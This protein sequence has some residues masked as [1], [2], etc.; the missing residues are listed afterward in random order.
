MRLKSLLAGGAAIA[1]LAATPSNA[2]VI[3]LIDQGFAGT[4][5]QQAQFRQGFQIAANYWGSILTNN[6]TI[7]LGVGTSALGTGI[8]GS[9]GS[10]RNDVTTA[11]WLAGINATKSSGALDTALVLPTL[12]AGGASF[13]TN[14]VNAAS[15][16]DD[17]TTLRYVNGNTTSAD[18]LYM[19]TSVVKA[20]GRT[21]SYN[22]NP[23]STGYN[24]QM[25]DGTVRFST[26]FGFDFD[27]TDG[28]SANTFDFIGVAIH[29]I[30]H[31]LGFV[32]GVD[33]LDIYGEGP[34]T[35]PNEGVLGYSLN[36]TSIYSALDMFR[37]SA[38]PTNAAPGSVAVLDLSAGD[39][40]GQKY[41]SIDGG[42][43]ALFG[44]TFSRGR[45]NSSDRQQASHWKDAPNCAIGNGLMD[46][47]F[48][49]EQ[50]GFVT[51]LDLAAFDAMGWNLSVDAL[52]Y[53]TTSTSVIY[54]QFATAPVPEPTTWVMMILGFGAIGAGMRRRSVKVAYAA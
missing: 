32:S 11:D 53:Q 6:V 9:T 26:N 37:Y 46:P 52:T 28:I 35:S 34:G 21:A 13:I 15:G 4:A 25:L 12:T 39:V 17:L 18:M 30:G 42:A 16:N 2:A 7:R 27:P 8:I 22:L 31:A 10:T 36:D 44:N 33:F 40:G 51:G 49:F 45:Y 54:N 14:G 19:N 1:V 3:Q 48:C 29:E 38:D 41:F 43:T 24:P 50:Q 23:A 20:I 5:A 47:T